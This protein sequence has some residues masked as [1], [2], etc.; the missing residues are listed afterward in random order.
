[1]KPAF[2]RPW[3]AFFV[4]TACAAMPAAPA[5]AQR[6]PE[7]N[8]A[9]LEKADQLRR[10]LRRMISLARDRVF[11]AMVNINVITVRYWAGKEVKGQ[12]VGSGTIISADGYVL[13]NF[14]VAENGQKFKCTLASKEEIS[15]TLVGEDP[16]TDLA[17]LK[18]DLSQRKSDGPLPFASF[19]DSDELEI[20]DTVMAMGSPWA[21]S[22][23]V[24]L[25]IVS[26]TDRILSG[27][28]DDAGE[29][30]FDRDQRTGLF[31]HWIQHDA[32]IN[33]G[34]SGGPLVNL[35]GEVIGVNTR[36]NSSGS[37]MGFAI[38]SNLARGVA[39]KLIELGRVPRSWY[40]FSLK[41][42]KK[43][44]LE[45]G[46][47]V[48]SIVHDGPAERGGI[49]AGDIIERIDGAPVT[50]RFPEQIPPLS[51]LLADKPVGSRVNLEGRHE[52]EHFSATIVT[53]PL[54]R[55]RGE[56]A[57]F[58]AW[59]LTAQ[60]ITEKM[61]RDRRL[62]TSEGVLVSSVRSGSPAQMAEPPIAR[63]DVIR[64]LGGEP[65]RNLR[66][67]IARYEQIMNA[68][69]SPEHLIVEFD[70]RGKNEITLIKPKSDRDVDPPREVPKA[71]IGVAT[72][73]LLRKLATQ[74]GHP[75]KLGFRITRVYPGTR[76]ADTELKVGDV[77]LAI[78]GRPL[79]PRGMQDAGMFQREIKKLD[80]D[81]TV[82]LSLLRGKRELKASVPLERT[83]LAAEDARR[84]VN[85]DFD[86][87]VRELTFFDRDERRW[88]ADVRG[89]LVESVESASWA[90]LAGLRP[91]D[92]IQRIG[93]DAIRG[94]KSYRAAMD[95][96]AEEKPERVVF[97]VL[98][99]V[100]T[101][102]Q[103]AEPEWDPVDKTAD[104]NAGDR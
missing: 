49:H 34:N 9:E 56:Q 26:N 25:G 29:M 80:R 96:I 68:D 11:P 22:R 51:K 75:D 59:G 12:S 48:N 19:G 16:L 17:V 35:K 99:G 78:D 70:R 102:F 18:L 4:A 23:S 91:G 79:T 67:F 90:G 58:R 76:A 52:G 71:W 82:E 13:T 63:G 61:A 7:L 33:P 5:L 84:D 28:D 89:V 41:S 66:E 1:M 72:Q 74:L 31:N 43:T 92:L 69:S 60:Q 88:D 21:L 47:L 62:T 85:R 24:T 64:S 30:Y 101:H 36:G 94:L 50:V 103:F 100:R 81:A 42:I 65:V 95:A 83:R 46:V 10:D 86:L 27:S 87:T 44:G 8:P 57:A 20:G 39:E 104:D 98:R 40:G 15:A 77:I 54:R 6:S 97:V 38:P 2:S 45:H 53:E 3:A 55:D 37:G 32:A 73:P 14:H 93:D